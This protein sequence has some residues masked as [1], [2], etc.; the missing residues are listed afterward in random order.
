MS[1]PPVSAAADLDVTVD[2]TVDVVVEAPAWRKAVRGPVALSTRAAR[3]AVA[4]ALPD[5][6]LA[7][8]A[9]AGVPLA[10][11]VALEDDAAVQALN[12]DFRGRDAPT[13]VL[14]F[15]ALEDAAGRVL[16]PPAETWGGDRDD[17]DEPE[18]LGD[19]VVALETTRDEAARAGKTLADHLSHLVVH[20]VLHLL[21]HDHQDDAEAAVM[22]GLETRILAGLGIADPYAESDAD[23]DADGAGEGRAARPAM[24]DP[25]T[26]D[27]DGPDAE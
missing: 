23:A 9:A 17:D 11:C 2:V 6:P 20:G 14:A 13:N 24:R 10:L 19:V 26:G 22:E 12:R 3:A 4:A 18:T 25:G 15:A 21:G 8:L 5:S 7:P 16:A 1:V 27:D